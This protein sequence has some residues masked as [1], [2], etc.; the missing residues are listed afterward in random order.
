MSRH[1]SEVVA[2][3]LSHRDRVRVRFVAPAD[4]EVRDLP[5]FRVADAVR[6]VSGSP[7]YALPSWGVVDVETNEL[8]GTLVSNLV[9]AFRACVAVER[10]A[11]Q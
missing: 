6:K 11:R 8:V 7:R 5:R 1:R 10:R 4:D 2:D 3:A 9:G